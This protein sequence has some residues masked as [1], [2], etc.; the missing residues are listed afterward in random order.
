MI[1]QRK[2]MGKSISLSMLRDTEPYLCGKVLKHQIAKIG[3][4]SDYHMRS[5]E[6]MA[7]VLIFKRAQTYFLKQDDQDLMSIEYSL[8][9]GPNTPREV[10]IS[11]SKPIAGISEHLHNRMPKQRSNGNWVLD[12]G[13]RYVV[14][15][16]KNCVIVDEN[17][18]EMF[19]AIKM[20]TD[21]LRIEGHPAIPDICTFCFAL[22]CFV[23]PL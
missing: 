22:S 11:F 14:S 23:C 20:D 3:K 12:F 17:D 19:V 5:S 16:V 15:S 1:R 4:G 10:K 2:K 8:S 18:R 21:V 7:V 13:G 6:P 9:D